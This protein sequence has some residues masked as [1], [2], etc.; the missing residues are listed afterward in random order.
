MSVPPN[1]AAAT[2]PKERYAQN[3][4]EKEG[5]GSTLINGQ[6][7]P[8]QAQPFLTD[9]NLLRL[10]PRPRRTGPTR[11]PTAKLIMVPKTGFHR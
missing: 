9:F 8:V 10:Q 5:K 2:A 1:S 6:A 11:A 3:Q 4:K 7:D